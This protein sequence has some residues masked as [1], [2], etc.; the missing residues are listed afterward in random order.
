MEAGLQMNLLSSLLKLTV[1]EET[2]DVLASL[3]S[4]SVIQSNCW[5]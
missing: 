2:L 5:G 3:D 4:G 1:R